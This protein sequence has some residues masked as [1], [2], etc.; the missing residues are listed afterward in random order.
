MF[1]RTRAFTLTELLVVIG[2]IAV[3]LAILL[4]AMGRAREQARDA[5]CRAQLRQLYFAQTFFAENNRGR[6]VGGAD[7][8]SLAPLALPTPATVGTSWIDRLAPYLAG[9]PDQPLAPGAFLN[10]PS[11]SPDAVRPRE[12]SYGVN[13]C[14]VLPNWR[15]RRDAIRQ[16]SRIILMGEK[17]PGATD[18]LVSDDGYCV[19][20]HRGTR[21]PSWLLN[22]LHNAHSSYRH[23]RGV[24]SNA[25][26]ADGH[27]ESLDRTQLRR[28]SGH[29][30]WE[31]SLAGPL[32]YRSGPCCPPPPPVASDQ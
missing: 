6:Y 28:D 20:E 2:I 24:G 32:L 31:D 10:C 13:S 19:Y 9:S 7:R 30:Y 11:V 8:G 15:T 18:F 3:M 14:A 26:M 22:V 5:E 25:V 12:A 1:R 17:T 29:W 27:V 16:A 23:Q 21:E 4:P